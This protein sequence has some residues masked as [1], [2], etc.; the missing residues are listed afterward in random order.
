MRIE[1][2]DRIGSERQGAAFSFIRAHE[3]ESADACAEEPVELL[4]KV[5]GTRAPE[6]GL[7]DM[8]ESALSWLPSLRE[9]LPEKAGEKLLRLFR[10]MPHDDRMIRDYRGVLGREDG[11]PKTPEWASEKC[12]VKEW[13]IKALARDWAKKTASIIHGNGG[14]YIRG[15]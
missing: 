2:K 6:G 11:V 14:C 4:K 13:T 15:P 12:G 10:A 5:H 1:L 8:R 3:Q 7:P 9:T